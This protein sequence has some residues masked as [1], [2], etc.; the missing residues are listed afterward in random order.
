MDWLIILAGGSGG[1]VGPGKNKVY[2]TLAGTPLLAYSLRGV[3][4]LPERVGLVLVARKQDRPLL[5]KILVDFAD[6]GAKVVLGGSTRLQSEKAGLAAVKVEPGDVIGV[7]DAA[8]PFVTAD[9]WRVCRETAAM[10]GGAVPVIES[11]HLFRLDGEQ[12]QR[13]DG[14]VRAQT[15]QLFAGPE[16]VDA[17]RYASRPGADT[18]ETVERYSHLSVAAVRGDP[19]NLKI[20]GPND[21]ERASALA[22]QWTPERWLTD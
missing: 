10:I 15:P 22:P 19:R 14:L 11:G 5:D 8:R 16:L 21:F 13:S 4:A 7:H 17:F 18:A 2:R 9:L 6:L 1:R 3:R 20:T 12:L